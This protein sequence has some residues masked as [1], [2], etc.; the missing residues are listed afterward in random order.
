MSTR[1]CSLLEHLAPRLKGVGAANGAATVRPKP[2]RA[3]AATVLAGDGEG[4]AGS[5]LLEPLA[6]CL[7][8]TAGV[9]AGKSRMVLG[10]RMSDGLVCIGDDTSQACG[11]RA[12][13]RM[14]S[15]AAVAVASLR[16]TAMAFSSLAGDQSARGGRGVVGRCHVRHPVIDGG[17][18][19][20][21]CE[22]NTSLERRQQRNGNQID[23]KPL[24]LS[25]SQAVKPLQHPVLVTTW[26][27]TI[28][29]ARLSRR[30]PLAT[31]PKLCSRQPKKHHSSSTKLQSMHWRR[32]WRRHVRP[33]R[34][35]SL[36]GL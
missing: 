36:R 14:L 10:R 2:S 11:S 21:C 27:G 6:H 23:D 3:L 28:Q 35:L 31:T 32:P 7:A 20:K 4:H 15:H 13:A 22:A 9:F 26:H 8:V 16:L 18:T 17:V 33:H 1:R 12:T 30:Q 24:R 34:W 25:G 29:H 5:M 19:C